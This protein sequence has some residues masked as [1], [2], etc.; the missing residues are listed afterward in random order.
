[1]RDRARAENNTEAL[2]A[3]DL[4]LQ[5]LRVQQNRI[6]GAALRRIE[7]IENERAAGAD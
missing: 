3:I 5:M 6:Y 7:E 1:M 2:R 4:Q